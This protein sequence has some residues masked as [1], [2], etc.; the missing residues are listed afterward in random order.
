MYQFEFKLDDSDY[1]EYNKY[2]RFNSPSGKKNLLIMRLL[3]PIFYVAFLILTYENPIKLIINF[4]FFAIISVIFFFIA[5]PIDILFLKLTLKAI[6]KDGK[7]PYGNDVLIQFDED[8]FVETTNESETKTNY[9][10]IEKIAVGKKAFYIY[11]NALQ[12]Y[13]IPFSVFKTEQHRDDFLAFI[14]NKTRTIG[15]AP[16]Y[17]RS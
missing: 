10:K 16:Q 11:V 2:H 8:F 14:N 13:I 12:A 17:G 5:K 3:A 4:F 1:L 7:L 9:S 15:D 6:K